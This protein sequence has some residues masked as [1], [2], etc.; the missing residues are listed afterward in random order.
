MLVFVNYVY[1]KLSTRGLNPPSEC[2][3][4]I[5]LVSTNS[6][7]VRSRTEI[8]DGSASNATVQCE[9]LVSGFDMS[10]AMAMKAQVDA[11]ARDFACEP[12]LGATPFSQAL[13]LWVGRI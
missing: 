2:G 3:T 4:R 7:F 12:R 11:L 9:G 10:A 13:I 6:D 8:L 5:Y 1:I